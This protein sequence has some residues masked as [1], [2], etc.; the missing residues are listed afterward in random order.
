MEL[1]LETAAAAPRNRQLRSARVYSHQSAP[2][3]FSL[4]L[5]WDTG[6]VPAHGSETALLILE[7]LRAY[8]MLD[9]TVLVEEGSNGATRPR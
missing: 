4:V 9:H 6:S 5:D 8:G 3:G 1:L 7:G 2:V